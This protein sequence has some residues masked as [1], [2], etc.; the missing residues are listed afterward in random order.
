MKSKKDDSI[1]AA[2]AT[3][4]KIVWERN[5]IY[6]FCCRN[7]F[8]HTHECIFAFCQ[9]CHLAKLEEGERG[10]LIGKKSRQSTKGDNSRNS[11][12]ATKIANKT[13][14]KSGLD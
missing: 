14:L 10:G 5:K 9:K 8:S 12:T 2:V 6:I 7:V 11:R 13:T 1:K 3:G 4:N